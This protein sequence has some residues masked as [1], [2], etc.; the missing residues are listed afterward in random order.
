MKY[1]P[2]G[3]D[4]AKHL[5]QV[6][7]INEYTGEVVDKQL[8]SKDFLAFFSNREPCL[9]GMEACGGSQYWARELEKLGHKVRLMQGRFVKAFV[10]G[11][12]NDVMDARA[13]WMAVQQPG[14]AIAVKTEEQ[15]SMLVLHRS[16]RQL[17]KFRT[18]QINALHGTLLEFGETIHK[19]REAM[20][21]ELPAALE[22]MKT[23][24][25]P[26]LITMLEDQY[27]RLNERDSL[28]NGLKNS[29]TV[30]RTRMK[31]VSG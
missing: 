23:K 13:I 19:G 18:A 10:M 11:N 25:P 14:K 9:I 21:R 22:R 3:V 12:K 17:V 8:R 27:N 6:H 5:I 30:W 20:D 31:P 4:I 15:Q 2:I 29:L 16:R 24:L 28:I 1:T 26:Y 7:F